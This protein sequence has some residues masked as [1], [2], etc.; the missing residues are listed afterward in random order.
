[1]DAPLRCQCYRVNGVC[2][3]DP[4]DLSH[5]ESVRLTKFIP[6]ETK[7]I[8]QIL[9]AVFPISFRM[10]DVSRTCFSFLE[11]ARPVILRLWF[12]LGMLPTVS[13][14][15]GYNYSTTPTPPMGSDPLGS[16]FLWHSAS[17]PVADG[18]NTVSPFSFTQV[19]V[20]HITSMP[21]AWCA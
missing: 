6:F 11:A 15:H 3:I 19:K 1:M 16:T 21:L 10:A 12:G 9:S 13:L 7:L 5:V 14:W 2:P 17:S 18:S 20:F 8:R 4:M